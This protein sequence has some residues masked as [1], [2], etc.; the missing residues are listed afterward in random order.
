MGVVGSE[1]GESRLSRSA[2]ICLALLKSRVSSPAVTKVL[3]RLF[4]LQYAMNNN[5]ARNLAL[6]L[7]FS[8]PTTRYAVPLDSNCAFTHAGVAALLDTISRSEAL[9]QAGD[10]PKDYLTIPMARLL[11]NEDF[12]KWN[13]DLR[14]DGSDGEMERMM[15]V[16]AL[17]PAGQSLVLQSCPSSRLVTTL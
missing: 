3:T 17:R 15:K 11:R 8:H 6:S 2:P 5:G 1:Q 16:E 14:F 13:N 4:T 9:E 12:A 7:S 10:K